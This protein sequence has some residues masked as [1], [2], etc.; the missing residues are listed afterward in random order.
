VLIQHDKIIKAR[1]LRYARN[2]R[3]LW[4]AQPTLQGLSNLQEIVFFVGQPFRVASFTHGAEK[5]RKA[6]ALPYLLSVLKT[7]FWNLAA[8]P[9]C[10]TVGTAYG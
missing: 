5:D 4:W 9:L 10:P 7:N 3:R 6:K 1:L 8:K 2:D